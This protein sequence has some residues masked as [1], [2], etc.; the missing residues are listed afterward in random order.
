MCIRDRSYADSK[1][2]NEMTNMVGRVI[3]DEYKDN[4][5]FEMRSAT[6]TGNDVFEVEDGADGK[7][8]VSYTHLKKNAEK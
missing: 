2:V 3:G 8:A 5:I 1:T 7:I 6:S 4:F